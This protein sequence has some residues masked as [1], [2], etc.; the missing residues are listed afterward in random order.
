MSENSRNFNAVAKVFLGISMAYAVITFVVNVIKLQIND[1]LGYSTGHTMLAL[2]NVFCL[3]ILVAG[4]FTYMKRKGGLIA[5]VLL[6]IF[7]PIASIPFGSDINIG[8]VLGV[9]TVPFLRD[10]LPFAIAMCFKKKGSDKSGW[11]SM[12]E[13]S[14]ETEAI[15]TEDQRQEDLFSQERGSESPFIGS[16]FDAC[17]ETPSESPIAAPES[18][19]AIGA[20]SSADETESMQELPKTEA[21]DANLHLVKITSNV[22]CTVFLDCEKIGTVSDETMIKKALKKGPYILRCVS[23]Y[24][25]ILEQSFELAKDE[26][27]NFKFQKTTGKTRR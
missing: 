14:D 24:N 21:A 16:L 10:F 7:K 8:Y 1:S 13:A 25:E 12:L 22:E 23:V 6:L 18:K 4:T 3:S 11:K 27:F 9:N 17:M 20:D 19:P 26:L 5:L 2:Q 15:P